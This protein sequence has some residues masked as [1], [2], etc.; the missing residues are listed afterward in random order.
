LLIGLGAIGMGY[1]IGHAVTGHVHTHARALQLSPAF[2]PVIGV[3][4][5]AERRELFASTYGGESFQSVTS[6]LAAHQPD[7][8]IISTPTE[9]HAETLRVVIERSRPRVILC[10]K[11]L[12]YDLDSARLMVAACEERGIELYVNYMRRSDPAVLAVKVMIE[13]GTIAAPVKAVVWYSKG[14]IHNGSHFI[15]LLSFWLGAPRQA[16]LVRAG[17][18]WQERDYEP[19]FVLDYAAGSASFLAADEERFSHY[20][21]ELL[22]QNGRL[23]YERGG[24]LVE[25]QGVVDDPESAGYRVLSQTAQR[26]R[27][28]MTNYQL[29]VTNQLAAALQGR[30]A[31]LCTGSEALDTLADIYRVLNLVTHA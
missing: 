28:D 7:I 23:R 2:G 17:R 15:N 20:T 8:V 19:D 6:A 27:S 1:D 16:V 3:D 14:L 21:V 4:V 30:V 5:N 13:D 22:A 18:R 25:W 9:T 11:P 10:E 26:L 29:T 12:D 24:E 31:S